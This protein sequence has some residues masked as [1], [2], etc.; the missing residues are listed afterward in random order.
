MS[1][2]PEEDPRNTPFLAILLYVL[3]F[4]GA[5]ALLAWVLARLLRHA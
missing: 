1:A 5:L 4:M 2:D 3:G